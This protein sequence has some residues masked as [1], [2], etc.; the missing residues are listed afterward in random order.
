MSEETQNNIEHS[1]FTTILSNMREGVIAVD[2]NARV[3]FL[4]LAFAELFNIDPTQAKDKHLLEVVRQNQL[5]VLLQSVLQ[6]QKVRTD[7]LRIFNPDEHNFQAIA[8]PL[9]ETGKKVGALMVLHDVT[10]VRRLEQVRRD[11]VANVSH[12]LRTPLAA[13]KGFSETLLSGA[14]SD[15]NA[16]LDFVKAIEKHTDNMTA[17]VEDLLDL[18]AIES[19]HQPPLKELIDLRVILREVVIGISPLARQKKIK[20]NF[21]VPEGMPMVQVDKKHI[22]QIFNNLLDNAL[23]FNSDS[24]CVELHSRVEG[25]QVHIDVIDSGIGIP[26]QDVSRIFERFYRVDKARSRAMGGT[27]LG[28]SIVKHLVE[29]NGGS[30]IVQSTIGTG[31]TFTVSIPYI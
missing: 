4:N 14:L 27:G 18:T 17:L 11:F 31:S 5:N 20:I 30:V 29:A 1:L 15:P 10:R 25:N 26:P 2:T 7:E 24:G 16:S 9:V 13:I 8:V 22:K 19:G 3:L 12:E 6:D 21:K 28:L 23:K